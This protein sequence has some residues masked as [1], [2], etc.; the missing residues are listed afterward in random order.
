VQRCVTVQVIVSLECIA[1]SGGVRTHVL[2]ISTTFTH[3]L[4][5]RFY[6]ASLHFPSI[7]LLPPKDM[8]DTL[9]R[10]SV[11]LDSR[12]VPSLAIGGGFIEAALPGVV[13]RTVDVSAL[14]NGDYV[15]QAGV[16]SAASSVSE[17]AAMYRE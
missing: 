2:A 9:L 3:T 1:W 6:H 16:K 15:A 4:A 8:Y 12:A 10:A 5:L 17:R 7:E 11:D 13:S 14:H